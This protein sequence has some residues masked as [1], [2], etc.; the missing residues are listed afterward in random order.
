MKLGALRPIQSALCLAARWRS[1]TTFPSLLRLFSYSDI[2]LTIA[3]VFVFALRN[4]PFQ[5][6]LLLFEKKKNNVT[7]KFYGSIYLAL[8]MNN[9]NDH[10]QN[11]NKA[12]AY[13]RAILLVYIY[14]SSYEYLYKENRIQK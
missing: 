12:R 14:I 4:L 10:T 2:C 1:N 13:A 3:R 11:L 9:P 5:T 7:F 6:Q 8:D